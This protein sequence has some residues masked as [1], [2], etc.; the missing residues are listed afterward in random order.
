LLTSCTLYSKCTCLSSTFMNLCCSPSFPI[1]TIGRTYTF[2]S[3]T[4]TSTNSSFFF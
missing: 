3:S 1:V 2:H 4:G